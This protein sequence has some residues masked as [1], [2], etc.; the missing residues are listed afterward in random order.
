MLK[1]G[2]YSGSMMKVEW[3]GFLYGKGVLPM[4]SNTGSSPDLQV[5]AQVCPF[6][7]K[8]C[9]L[10]HFIKIC[11]FIEFTD[12]AAFAGVLKQR[13]T[14][15]TVESQVVPSGCHPPSKEVAGDE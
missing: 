12:L 2:N 14:Q 3:L 6:T 11:L 5:T 10:W 9:L 7:V 8:K 1:F 13:Q 15:S 4:C